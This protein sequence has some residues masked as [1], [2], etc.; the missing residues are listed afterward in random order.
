MSSFKT[1]VRDVLVE[2][3]REKSNISLDYYH[4]IGHVITIENFIF[5]NV[6]KT[7]IVID[8][9]CLNKQSTFYYSSPS[10]LDDVLSTVQDMIVQN[11]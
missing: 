6:L 4:S 1:D 10:F 9:A 7:C 2:L 11:K 5:I 8:D 3:F